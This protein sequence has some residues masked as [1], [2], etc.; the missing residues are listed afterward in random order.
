MGGITGME[1]GNELWRQA[2]SSSF[3]AGGWGRRGWMDRKGETEKERRWGGE[4]KKS[5]P[6]GEPHCRADQ[7]REFCLTANLL[8]WSGVMAVTPLLP[9]VCWSVHCTAANSP[10]DSYW[11][12]LINFL[13]EIMAS[14]EESARRGKTLRK[15][16]PY[17]S[18][19]AKASPSSRGIIYCFLLSR[20]CPKNEIWTRGVNCLL[21]G[22]LGSRCG[23]RVSL[24]WEDRNRLHC[25]LS[26]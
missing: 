10:I 24:C 16:F 22:V 8:F 2:S 13:P 23:F 5:N 18:R 26:V 4:C 3:G 1:G 6:G 14:S 12:T 15:T 19:M 9:S 25:V 7:R 11:A 20:L 21:S 17:I